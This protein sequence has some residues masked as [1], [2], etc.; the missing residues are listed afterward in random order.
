MCSNTSLNATQSAVHAG[1]H[2]RGID[3][4]LS[5]PLLSAPRGGLRI[6]LETAGVELGME[7]RESLQKR[8]ASTPDAEK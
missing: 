3:Q 2:R 6:E 5:W 1:R 8:P 4:R 7:L